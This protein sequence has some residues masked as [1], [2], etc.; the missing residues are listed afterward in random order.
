MRNPGKVRRAVTDAEVAAI[1]MYA[2]RYVQYRL[3]YM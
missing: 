1:E 2:D 3:D